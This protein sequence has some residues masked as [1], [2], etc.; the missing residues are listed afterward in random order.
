[1]LT[2]PLWRISEFPLGR[3]LPNDGTPVIEETA[4]K[5]QYTKNGRPWGVRFL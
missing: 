4:A 2:G 5:R 1:M 3:P